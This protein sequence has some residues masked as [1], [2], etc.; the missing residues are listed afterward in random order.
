[1]Y[2]FEEVRIRKFEFN[3]INKKIEWINNPKNN[4]FLHFDLPLEY[5]KTCKWFEKNKDNKNRYDAIIE[6]KGIPVGIVGLLD[7]DYKNKKCEEYITIGETNLKRKGI[8]TK[9]LNLI[10]L[11][12]F[13]ILKLNKVIAYV[14]YGNPSLYLHT[15]TGFEIEGFLKNDLIMD[16]KIVD[17]FILGI[18]EKNLNNLEK[19]RWVDD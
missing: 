19:V 5:E 8:G 16:E 10:C 7:I 15:K 18:F 6:Y 12:A 9:A 3:D 17:R 4:K 11:Y 1:M 14:E 2:E 13:K